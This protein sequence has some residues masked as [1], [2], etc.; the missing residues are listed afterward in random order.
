MKKNLKPLLIFHIQ[1]VLLTFLVSLFMCISIISLSCGIELMSY[2][3]P[4][5]CDEYVLTDC[6][7]FAHSLANE[8]YAE[9]SDSL[10][11]SENI[12]RCSTAFILIFGIFALLAILLDKFNDTLYFA[13]DIMEH[14]KQ[15]P[16]AYQIEV[17]IWLPDCIKAK[18]KYDAYIKSKNLV[19]CFIPVVP[20]DDSADKQ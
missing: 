3:N 20:F 4:D 13:F 2:A 8:F 11:Y 16:E 10:S 9:H 19:D 6:N 17:P 15:N 7:C 5:T 14:N 12:G 18:R 1:G